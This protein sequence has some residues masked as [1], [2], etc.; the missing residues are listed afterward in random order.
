MMRA[1]YIFLNLLF[2]TSLFSSE[3]RFLELI[4][5]NTKMDTFNRP[6]LL[7]TGVYFGARLLFPSTDD[8]Q[9]AKYIAYPTIGACLAMQVCGI[10]LQAYKDREK[11]RTKIAY[12]LLGRF[13]TTGMMLAVSYYAYRLVENN[14]E[15]L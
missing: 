5:K 9:K 11:S 14:R 3:N 7:A 4:R 8:E 1:R 2:F 13:I 12:H 6:Y 10:F 15:K